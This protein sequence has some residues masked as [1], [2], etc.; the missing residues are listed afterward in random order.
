MVAAK[1]IKYMGA[2]PS[3]RLI[4]IGKLA[5]RGEW[6]EVPADYAA[7]LE[8]HPSWEVKGGKKAAKPGPI[9]EHLGD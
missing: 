2:S 4:R 5:V 7:E 6:I 9:G 8:G 1:E 3:V